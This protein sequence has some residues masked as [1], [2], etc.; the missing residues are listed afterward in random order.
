MNLI[1]FGWIS[2]IGLS[3][4][5][6]AAAAPPEGQAVLRACGHGQEREIE[7]PRARKPSLTLLS[8]RPAESS[9]V[10][11]ETVVTAELEYD[12]DRFEPGM[13]QVNVQFETVDPAF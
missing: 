7:G 1:R 6:I 4:A 8:M 9:Y 13:Y 2:F 3:L 12:I 11:D 5:G 10:T